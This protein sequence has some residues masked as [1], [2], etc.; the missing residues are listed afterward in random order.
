MAR[1]LLFIDTNIWLDF[2]RSETEAG[3]RL[4]EHVNSISDRIIVCPQVEMEFKKNRQSIILQSMKD[5]NGF[6]SVTR[7]GILSDAKAAKALQ[8]TL[9]RADQLIKVIKGYKCPS[10]EDSRT[11]FRTRPGI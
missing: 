9:K 1:T 8:K 2:Y 11:P 6:K 10:R 4:L 3:I 7:P 5:L